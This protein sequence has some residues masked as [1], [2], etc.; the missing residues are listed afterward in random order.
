MKVWLRFAFSAKGANYDSPGRSVIR[1]GPG[2][3]AE[4]ECE[5]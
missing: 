3:P 5:P 1:A 4:I 2:T